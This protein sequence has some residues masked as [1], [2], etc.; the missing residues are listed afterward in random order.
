MPASAMFKIQ[1][2]TNMDVI[3]VSP[4]KSVA[5]LEAMLKKAWSI[6]A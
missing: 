4:K 6:I 3:S 5:T 2:N 1:D